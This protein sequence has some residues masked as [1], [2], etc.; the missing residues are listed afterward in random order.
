AELEALHRSLSPE[1]NIPVLVEAVLDSEEEV[2]DLAVQIDLV[3]SLLAEQPAAKKAPAAELQLD[4]GY[5]LVDAADTPLPEDPNAN[6]SLSQVHNDPLNYTGDD[7]FINHEDRESHF[8]Q[9]PVDAED[10]DEPPLLEL[11]DALP[12][13]EAVIP[14]TPD[15]SAA[16]LDTVFKA[17]SNPTDDQDDEN[18]FLPAHLREKL[19][20]SKATLI[21]E[22]Q[23]SSDAVHQSSA[24]IKAYTSD[25]QLKHRDRATTPIQP[26]KESLKEAEPN[27]ALIDELVAEFLPQIEAKLRQK[28]AEQLAHKPPRS[29]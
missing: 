17:L 21:E 19:R 24:L 29:N 10:Q 26:Q 14:T 18:P 13:A 8:T 7:L 9:E 27:Q 15:S 1:A 2:P 25:S 28:L 16:K 5:D 20:R 4:L 22:I 6:E 12:S 3:D 23:R 11:E